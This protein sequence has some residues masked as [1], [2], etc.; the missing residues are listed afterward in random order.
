M[1]LWA[2]SAATVSVVGEVPAASAAS[3]RASKRRRVGWVRQARMWASTA[4]AGSPR[5][6]VRAAS[7]SAA[8]ANG[9]GVVGVRVRA[10]RAA[11]VAS[12]VRPAVVSASIQS[13]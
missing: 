10:C 7:R 2:W 9:S 13:R 12:A 4:P 5:R 6:V 11:S 3:V 8:W 1:R